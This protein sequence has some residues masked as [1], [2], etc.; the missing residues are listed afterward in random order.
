MSKLQT[1]ETMKNF[2]I[3]L[4]LVLLTAGTAL[5]QSTPM[6]DE[7]QEAQRARI[8][9]GAASGDLTRAETAKLRAEQ[10]HIRRSERRMKSDGV[11]THR[12][13]ARLHRKQNK[14]SRDIRRQKDDVQRVN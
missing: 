6:A 2:L 10:R 7:R 9:E 1:S 12:E 11:V 14:A 8:R 4:M 13:R 3:T 5:S